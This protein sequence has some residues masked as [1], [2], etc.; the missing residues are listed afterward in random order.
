MERDGLYERP[1]VRIK[2]LYDLD[3]VEA[4]VF[5]YWKIMEHKSLIRTQDLKQKEEGARA[6][7]FYIDKY[8]RYVPKEVQKRIDSIE[9]LN[10]LEKECNKILESSVTTRQTL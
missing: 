1:V 10:R 8:R 5:H 7:L 4:I 6:M 9:D 2:D 3:G